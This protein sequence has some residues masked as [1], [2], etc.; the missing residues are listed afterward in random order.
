MTT[1]TFRSDSDVDRALDYLQ[2]RDGLTKSVVTRQAIL[3]AAR[4]A[5]HADLLAESEALLNDPADLTEARQV[6][7]EMAAI[8]AW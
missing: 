6:T 3:K 1:L 8:G 7:A 2:R 4:D 5:R